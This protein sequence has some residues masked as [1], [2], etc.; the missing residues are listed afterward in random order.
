MTQL[1]S[2][3]RYIIILKASLMKGYIDQ[4]LDNLEHLTIIEERQRTVN[5]ID[6]ATLYYQANYPPTIELNNT[7]KKI[8][9]DYTK[10]YCPH[11]KDVIINTTDSALQYNK[12][13]CP[14]AKELDLNDIG[15]IN[16]M[17]IATITNYIKNKRK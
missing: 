6:S 13:Y 17:K 11:I 7:P 5:I 12:N 10:K 2:T 14:P 16:D 1:E 4:L 9:I 8:A 3:D 15:F